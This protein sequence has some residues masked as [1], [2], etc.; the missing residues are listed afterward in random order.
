MVFSISLSIQWLNIII[1]GSEELKIMTR[2]KRFGRS[3]GKKSGDSH[4]PLYKY[5]MIV[6]PQTLLYVRL[7]V[8]S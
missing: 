4:C 7:P 2:E 3:H 8:R 5:I 6:V 1:L